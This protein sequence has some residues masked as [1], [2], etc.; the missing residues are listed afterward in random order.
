M[1]SAGSTPCGLGVSQP[2]TWATKRTC[3]LFLSSVYAWPL[4]WNRSRTRIA[5]RK[6]ASGCWS[7]IAARPSWRGSE[8]PDSDRTPYRWKPLG[9]P[10][11]LIRVDASSKGTRRPSAGSGV[12]FDLMLIF[13]KNHRGRV[14]LC[15]RD[16]GRQAPI[17]SDYVSI[18]GVAV[19]T[20]PTRRYQTTG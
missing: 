12:C 2:V 14:R 11:G 3:D 5:W 8:R 19:A 13:T 9:R 15:D 20:L 6:S 7:A 17:S 1:S 10:T 18:D 16:D 4:C